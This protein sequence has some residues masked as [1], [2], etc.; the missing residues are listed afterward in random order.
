MPSSARDRFVATVD[1]LVFPGRSDGTYYRVCLVH[2]PETLRTYEEQDANRVVLAASAMMNPAN[3]FRHVTS[4][5]HVR[6]GLEPALWGA[7][8]LSYEVMGLDRLVTAGLRPSYLALADELDRWSN[9]AVTREE[10]TTRAVIAA[11]RCSGEGTLLTRRGHPAEGRDEPALAYSVIMLKTWGRPDRIR[12]YRMC[13][14]GNGTAGTLLY[15]TNAFLEAVARDR[16]APLEVA[17]FVR[18]WAL[19]AY[20]QEFLDVGGS[21]DEILALW[22]EGR[23]QDLVDRLQMPGP[24][25]HDSVVKLY[26]DKMGLQ[27]VGNP[28]WWDRI[29]NWAMERTCDGT[30][31]DHWLDCLA[32]GGS[33]PPLAPP[34][35]PHAHLEPLADQAQAIV[36]ALKERREE[37]DWH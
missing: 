12:Y 17:G 20:A 5:P 15:A 21:L 29:A 22:R 32:R 37:L 34:A 28:Y 23:L 33:E 16:G 14:R 26:A 13:G 3:I 35:A 10:Q 9:C 27:V 1:P 11:V 4:E 7:L 24:G 36:A 8:E 6:E 25:N 19:L 31:S 30:L 2:R 18:T